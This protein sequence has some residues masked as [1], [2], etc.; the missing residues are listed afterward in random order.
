LLL[1]GLVAV[2]ALVLVLLLGGAVVGFTV[3][4][5]FGGEVGLW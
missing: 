1:G 4:F 3:V 5:F 2:H